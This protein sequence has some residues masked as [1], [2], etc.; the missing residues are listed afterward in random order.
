[1]ILLIEDDELE[2]AV[3]NKME[4]SSND[5]YASITEAFESEKQC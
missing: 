3:I 1:M 2:K 4:E 5:K